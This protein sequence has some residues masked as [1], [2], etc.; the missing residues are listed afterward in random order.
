MNC[1][2]LISTYHVKG[3]SGTLMILDRA[4]RPRNHDHGFRPLPGRMR[5][6]DD[7]AALLRLA[8]GEQRSAPLLRPASSLATELASPNFRAARPS[9]SVHANRRINGEGKR[10]GRRQ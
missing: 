6:A 3:R 4:P 10:E 5:R 7:G 1:I 9:A 2:M 8:A